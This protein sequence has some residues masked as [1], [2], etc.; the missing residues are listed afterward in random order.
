MHFFLNL[1]IIIYKYIQDTEQTLWT[2]YCAVC[3]SEWKTFCSVLYR[4][5]FSIMFA[6]IF[7]THMKGLQSCPVLANYLALLLS[8]AQKIERITAGC[9]YVWVYVCMYVC[10]HVCMYLCM[11]VFMYVCMYVRVYVCIVWVNVCKY[12]CMYAC[13]KTSSFVYTTTIP[14]PLQTLNID[15]KYLW[16]SAMCILLSELF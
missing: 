5:C 6:K 7:A 2:V 16:L 12:V 10:M 14:P 15:I 13:K 1:F 9:L 4:E 3:N 8:Q 11:Y